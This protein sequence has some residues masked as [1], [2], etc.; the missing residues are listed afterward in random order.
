M[1]GGSTLNTSKSMNI[2]VF[3][4]TYNRAYS[5]SHLY[6]SLLHQSCN[7]F[8][9]MIVDDG[10]VDNTEELI[11]SFVCENKILIRYIK[12]ENGGKHRA[13]NKGVQEAK[14]ELFFIVDSDD[15]LADNAIERVLFYYNTIK[16]NVLFGGVCG[17]KSYF[18]GGRVG[19]KVCFLELDCNVLDL[20]YKH[21]VKGDMA[22]VY[23]KDILKKYSFPEYDDEKFCP[24]ALIWNR[25]AQKY[26]LRFFNEPI[27]FCEYLNDGLTSKIVELRMNSPLASMDTYSELSM[28]HIPY[29]QKYKAAINFWR[30]SFNT[31]KISLRMKLKKIGY[32][33]TII[34]FPLGFIMYLNDIR[35]KERRI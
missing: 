35:K 13:I 17:C 1:G 19:G 25:I 20:R 11:Q 5:I 23:K 33:K 15:Y 27:Y 2:T 16:N 21:K 14:G 31:K 22:E 10:S 8:E 9:W 32:L 18:S 4:A 28:H 24:E 3:T 26:Q 7:D 6:Q 12:Q 29:L 34:S 30:F